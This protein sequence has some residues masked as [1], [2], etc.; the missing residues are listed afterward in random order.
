MGEIRRR[1]RH[2]VQGFVE[3]GGRRAGVSAM[4]AFQE[5]GEDLRVIGRRAL[6][7][8]AVRQDLLAQAPDAASAGPARRQSR[9]R[10]RPSKNAEAQINALMFLIRWLP[11][12]SVSRLSA[13]NAICSAR[14]A[15]IRD[16]EGGRNRAAPPRQLLHPDDDA[17][18]QRV[19]V[20][21]VSP[22]RPFASA[23]SRRSSASIRST[24][25]ASSTSSR[26]SM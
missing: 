12:I 17:Q 2:R 4:P 20:P 13:R 7:M 25:A 6:V 3:R 21:T 9:A 22:A 18:R 26:Y 15:A 1:D 11:P 5:I 24:N 14:L 10:P 23:D 19:A 8:H 16:S